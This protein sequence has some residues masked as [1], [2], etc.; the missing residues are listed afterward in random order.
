[1]AGFLASRPSEFKRVDDAISWSVKGGGVR[2]LESAKI[3]IPSQL[4]EHEGVWR[5]RTDLNAS[6]PHW[7]GWFQGI[8]LV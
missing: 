5:W 1:M 4:R 3:S 2:N 7:Q 6:K 8:P